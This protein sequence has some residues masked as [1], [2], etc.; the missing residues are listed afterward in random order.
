MYLKSIT[1]EVIFE[2]YF[3]TVKRAMEAAV[4]EH[5]CLDGVD[6]RNTNLSQA[7]LDGA[8]MK[9]VCLWGANLTGVNM[10]G[11]EMAGADCRNANFK[12][13]CLAESDCSK[14]DFR[15]S[16]FSNSVLRQT[17]LSDAKFS[18]PSIFNN[19][20]YEVGNLHGAVYSHKG[21]VECDM[22]QT[23]IIIHGVEKPIILLKDKILIGHFLYD[24]GT[25]QKIIT[26]FLKP[27]K[28]ENNIQF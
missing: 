17:D 20:L 9:G 21:E 18:C 2:G 3:H 10:S 16:Y 19:N 25:Y 26:H 5:V 28:K 13:C 11:V 8:Q 1:G 15:G 12:D 6:L 4:R 14:T 24:K 7:N 27:I 23:P 22:S